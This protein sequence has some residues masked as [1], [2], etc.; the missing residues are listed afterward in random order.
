MWRGSSYSQDIS[1]LTETNTWRQTVLE[2]NAHPIL[3]CRSSMVPWEQFLGAA[4]LLQGLQ[5][6]L[7][8]VTGASKGS[9]VN[10]CYF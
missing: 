5:T 9:H 3:T 10:F 7:K 8:D 1:V 2:I 4:G 6:E